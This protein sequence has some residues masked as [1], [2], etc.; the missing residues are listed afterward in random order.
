[1]SDFKFFAGIDWGASNHQVALVDDAGQL[2]GNRSFRHD[3]T[4]L[5]AMAC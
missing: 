1:M 5:A 3:G 2:L 4:G